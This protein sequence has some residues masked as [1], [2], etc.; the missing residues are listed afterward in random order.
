MRFPTTSQLASLYFNGSRW[1]PNKRLRNLLDAGLVKAWVR[2]LSEENV[3]SVTR[4]GIRAIEIEN[5]EWSK[6]K[7]PY[8]MDENLKHLLAINDVRTS[9]AIALPAADAENNLVAVRWELRSHG[10]ERI[11]PDGLFLI[12]WAAPCTSVFCAICLRQWDSLPDCGKR[13]PLPRL[14]ASQDSRHSGKHP[15][16]S[17]ACPCFG[18]AF[19]TKIARFCNRDPF[20]PKVHVSPAKRNCFRRP[21]SGPK[22]SIDKWVVER[23]FVSEMSEDLVPFILG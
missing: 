20:C 15:N 18:L 7:I 13:N 4:T 1:Y 3:Y 2:T 10:R 17:F 14:S 19:S 8:L 11:I 23:I 12:K 6:T 21:H 5:G 22:L 16:R 9:L